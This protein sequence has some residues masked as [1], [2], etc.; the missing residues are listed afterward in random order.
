MNSSSICPWIVSANA[1]TSIGYDLETTAAAVRAQI[2][3]FGESYM[4]D[5]SGN[6]MVVSCI[7]QLDENCM[8]SSRII[9][10]TLAA[11]QPLVNQLAE[12]S[13]DMG[14]FPVKMAL[15]M[16]RPGIEGLNDEM[17]KE[18]TLTFG[19]SDI[20][21]YWENQSEGHGSVIRCVEDAVEILSTGQAELCLVGGADTYWHYESLEWLD[22]TRRLRSDSNLDGF[23]PGEAAAFILLMTT[24]CARRLG[25]N[26]MAEVASV[27]CGHEPHPLISDGVSIGSG[28][29][30]TLQSVLDRIQGGLSMVD[31]VVS[32]MNGE[33][34][35]S[36]EWS[37][38]WMRTGQHFRN[39]V[40]LWHPA[41]CYGDVGS[42]S[43]ALLLGITANALAKGY[44]R[45]STALVFTSSEGPLRS[46]AVLR[47][48]P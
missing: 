23:V 43:G 42:A 28:L 8:G 6:P 39:P 31:W 26:A 12:L 45:G 33:S 44:G 19:D 32:D 18:L 17:Y 29:T 48:I 21:I 34:Y 1:V 36:M 35:R 4:I 5:K 27:A 22:Q 3:T 10:L 30:E 41:D 38:A 37:Y 47:S 40:E 11:M 15:P 20:N 7:K 9:E 13:V 2:S 25:L 24:Q 16:S 46:A 14:S